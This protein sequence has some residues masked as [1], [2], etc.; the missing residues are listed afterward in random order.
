M[1]KTLKLAVA[2]FILTMTGLAFSGPAYAEPL[3]GQLVIN[4]SEGSGRLSAVY[5]GEQSLSNTTYKWYRDGSEVGTTNEYK[6]TESG[7]YSCEMT[8]SNYEG[9]LTSTKKIVLYTVSGKKILVKNQYGLYEQGKTVTVTADLAE[10]EKVTNWK[11]NVSGVNMPTSGTSVSFKMPAADVYIT[12]ET[13]AYYTVKVVGG[14]ADKYTASPGDVIALTASEVDGKK[15]VSW[16]TTGG[17]ISNANNEICYVTMPNKNIQCT[18]N[19][20]EKPKEDVAKQKAD[21][22]ARKAAEEE[23]KKPKFSS[24]TQFVYTLPWSNNYKVTIKHAKQGPVCDLA[25]KLAAGGDFL[26][27]DYFNIVI[28]D[29][30]EI[31]ETPTPITV[32]LTLPADLQWGGRH[33]RVLCV[34]RGGFV[35]SFP[36]EDEDDTTVTFSPDRFYA[37]ALC[38]NDNPDPVIEEAAES[39]V[40]GN[41]SG[42]VVE[43]EP[44]EEITIDYDPALAPTTEEIEESHSY[45]PSASH[46]VSDSQ[47]VNPADITRPQPTGYSAPLN[48]ESDKQSAIR[49]ANGAKIATL[50]M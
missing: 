37:F 28:N 6:P 47:T 15:F 22:A 14:T 41:V 30:M 50:P 1:L 44:E 7:S 48:V 9:K 10:N 12:V 33:W 29:N 3:E 4:Y 31:R 18:A 5:T 24:P 32:C 16:V 26:I 46:A 49:T 35:Y 27:L 23:A 36:D 25:F 17:S 34:S 21:E 43:P 13:K 8:D 42:N 45:G 40:S 38:Y 11:V 39:T 19:F 20:S 2:A